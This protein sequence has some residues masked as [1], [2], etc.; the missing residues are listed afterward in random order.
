MMRRRFGLHGATTGSAD[1]MTD[2]AAAGA[3][4]FDAL[5][6]HGAKL[7]A[8]IARG[9][10]LRELRA[11]LAPA[12]IEPLSLVPPEGWVPVVGAER[13]TTLRRWRTM[14]ACAAAIGCRC[15]TAAPGTAN[16]AVDERVVRR[17]AVAMLSEMACIADAF[18]LRVAFEFR[19]PRHGSVSTLAAARAIVDAVHH[20]AVGLVIDAFHFHAGCSTYAMLD[21]LDPA[22]VCYVRLED[23]EALPPATLTNSHRLLPGDGVIPLRDFVCRLQEIGCNGVYSIELGGTEY[24]DWGAQRL[25]R[26]ARESLEACCAE[27]DEREGLLDYA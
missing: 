13:D 12:R 25:A 15:I 14:C 6:I 16:G 7:Y 22:L 24:G 21:A 2:L 27:L 19:C 5:E 23:A 26:V 10:T 20:P 11:A 17:E 3:A 9:G 1:L 4:G 18:G 8:Y